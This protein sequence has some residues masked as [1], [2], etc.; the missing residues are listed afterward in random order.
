MWHDATGAGCGV[1]N[2]QQK[3][4]SISIAK[5]CESLSAVTCHLKQE[6]GAGGQ[7]TGHNAVTINAVKW[8]RSTCSLL[9][10]WTNVP[11]GNNRLPCSLPQLPGYERGGGNEITGAEKK[12]GSQ[13]FRLFQITSFLS[14]QQL[15]YCYSIHVPTTQG[16]YVELNQLNFSNSIG[17]ILR[18]F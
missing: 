5:L 16:H 11:S 6:K 12:G 15:I 2:G 18:K 7:S 1:L 4:L 3:Q 9:H 17:S 8:T 14:Y 10:F 13:I